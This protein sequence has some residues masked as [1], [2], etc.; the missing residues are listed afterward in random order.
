MRGV[1]VQAKLTR[2]ELNGCVRLA[3]TFEAFAD[4]KF[5][6]VAVDGVHRVIHDVLAARLRL[7]IAVFPEA[8]KDIAMHALATDRNT[9]Q[10][11]YRNDFA[12]SYYY[13]QRVQHHVQTGEGNQATHSSENAAKYWVPFLENQPPAGRRKYA[14]NNDAANC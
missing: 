11:P 4:D 6:A 10:S 7:E 9:Q 1:I 13:L 5:I 3:L 14:A 2:H 8:G 12:A